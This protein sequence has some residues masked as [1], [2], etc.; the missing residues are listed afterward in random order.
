MRTSSSRGG[1][2][3]APNSARTHASASP[4]NRSNHEHLPVPLP[5]QHQAFNCGLALAILD[6]LRDRGFDTGERPVAVGLAKT[7]RM[8]RL[9]EVWQTP[10]ILIDGAHTT[11]SIHALIKAIGAHIRYDSM[12]VIFGCAA[13]KDVDGMID[14]IGL[15]ADKIIFTKSASNPRAAD[16]NDLKTLFVE[17]HGKMAQVE[18]TLKEAINVA[19]RAVGRGDL[20]LVTGSFYPRR[21]GQGAAPGGVR[22]EEGREPG[23]AQGLIPVGGTIRPR[24]RSEDAR[25]GSVP[26]PTSDASC[27]SIGAVILCDRWTMGRSVAHLAGRHDRLGH[28]VRERG[29]RVESR[30]DKR[31]G[32]GH[33]TECQVFES[34]LGGGGVRDATPRRFA[35]SDAPRSAGRSGGR[36]DAGGTNARA[37]SEDSDVG[38]AGAVGDGRVPLRHRTRPTLSARPDDEGDLDGY[39]DVVVAIGQVSFLSANDPSGWT[40]SDSSILVFHNTQDWSPASDGLDEFQE[41]DLPEFT[42]AAEVVWADITGDGRLD[43]VCSTTHHYD[44]E[45]DLGDW[46]IYVYAWDGD[47]FG[48]NPYQY[49]ASTY[50]LRGLVADDFDNDGDVDVAAAIDWPEPDDDERDVLAIFDNE[51]GT[52]GSYT[53]DD[54]SLT[55]RF[56]ST[57]EAPTGQLV[58]GLFD[59]TPGGGQYPDIFTPLWDD[60]AA[61]LTG[62]SSGFT[63]S[64]IS[65]SSPCLYDGATGLTAARFTSGKLTDDIAAAAFGEV[66]IYHGDGD[67]EFGHECGN[68][69]N[70]IYLDG[71][72]CGG[73]PTFFP[74]DIASGQLN[75]GTKA[76]LVFGIPS[77]GYTAYVWL[78]LGKGDGSFQF[79]ENGSYQF[80]ETRA[81]FADDRRGASAGRDAHPRA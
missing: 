66:H 71:G 1:S 10:R 33:V 7:P 47:D 60:D 6:K 14:K 51:G 16:P 31:E 38:D 63:T 44:N 43:I 67:A 34:C 32:D 46:G 59:K 11:D 24:P 80:R 22:Q 8:G 52:A 61:S 49:I 18:P 58:S 54:E 76:D 57:H 41:I 74:Y 36:G 73:A 68:E 39:P 30:R 75:G 70:D 2:S 3:P 55:S 50:P 42:I 12:V 45:D 15:G 19:A 69:P 53:L 62:S 40:E 37:A 21:R 81:R 5:G 48:V 65:L 56:M 20:I 9:E 13:D 25:H 64:I 27:G 26:R 79:S 28:G 35:R 72:C 78:L 77:G 23:R 4:A 17:R 29:P